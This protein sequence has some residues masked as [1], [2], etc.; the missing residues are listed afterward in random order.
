MWT[1]DKL[2][3]GYVSW[4]NGDR[5]YQGPLKDGLMHGKGKQIWYLK[6]GNVDKKY[7]GEYLDGLKHGQGVM[8]WTGGMRFDGGWRK[9]K[10]HG[11]A[12]FTK[13]GK[14]QMGEWEDG[15]HLRWF[16]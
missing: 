4:N 14:T 11:T 8:E 2:N 9:G 3:D 16:N 1:N 6:D 5:L 10:Q 7:E 15:N 12:R 13:N